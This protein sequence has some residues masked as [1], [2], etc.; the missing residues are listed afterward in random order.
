MDESA[1]TLSPAPASYPSSEYNSATPRNC[2][3]KLCFNKAKQNYHS[4]PF[5]LGKKMEWRTPRWKL[6]NK[7]ICPGIPNFGCGSWRRSQSTILRWTSPRSPVTNN[8]KISGQSVR[9]RTHTQATE[10]VLL[11]FLLLEL[12][13]Y[14]CFICSGRELDPGGSGG[15][16]PSPPNQPANYP[17]GI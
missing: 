8:T 9:A 7:S 16:R 5:A 13:F 12:T 11:L 1:A 2:F 14:F 3:Y 17:Q 4:L 6:P 15:R 10:S